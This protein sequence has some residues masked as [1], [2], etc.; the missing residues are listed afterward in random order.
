MQISTDEVPYTRR[1]QRAPGGTPAKSTLS[2]LLQWSSCTRDDTHT[3]LEIARPEE[4]LTKLSLGCATGRDLRAILPESIISYNKNKCTQTRR[5]N[6][7]DHLEA[8]IS[9]L[10]LY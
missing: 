3:Q 1:S 2:V 8:K 9:R 7:G 4:A 6:S 10:P 5:G